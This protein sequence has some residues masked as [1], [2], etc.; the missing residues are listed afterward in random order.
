VAASL[1]DLLLFLPASCIHGLHEV[2]AKA[3]LGPFQAP[4]LTQGL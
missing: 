3:L 4:L 1:F 2:A